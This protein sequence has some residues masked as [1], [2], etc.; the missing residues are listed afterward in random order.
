MA[1]SFAQLIYGAY[2][3][4]GNLKRVFKWLI[5]LAATA[6][7]LLYIIVATVIAVL[8]GNGRVSD[9]VRPDSV[10]FLEFQSFS[11]KTING[12]IWY[13]FKHPYQFP[14]LG[15]VTQGVILDSSAKVGK[16]HIAWDIA[17][18]VSR[19]TEVKAFAEGTVIAVNPNIL[20]N[21]T[22]RWKFCD[23]DEGGVC[24]YVVKEKADVQYGCGYEVIIQHADS[25]ST[26]Y[27]HLASEPALKAGDPV[28]TGQII[29]YQGNT[30]YATGKHLHLA[31]WRGGQPID[32]SYAFLQTSLSD[33]EK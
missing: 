30:G 4:R 29:G 16:K 33:W 32:P 31:L 18:K 1:V 11:Y 20:Y 5:I 3:N 7:L 22:R 12:D 2:K 19:Q 21:T 23:E 26:Q 27:C 13:E 9:S 25:L 17:D 28:T 15:A 6:F 8:Q 10:E 24:W 14:T